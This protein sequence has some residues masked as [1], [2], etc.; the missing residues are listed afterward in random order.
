M[1]WLDRLAL[2]VL[3]ATAAA[4]VLGELGRYHWLLELLSHFAVQ[5]AVALAAAGVY[6]LLRRR[7][8]WVVVAV[9]AMLLPAWRL[10][11]YLPVGDAAI[12][13]A[14]TTNR[15]RVMT[16]NVHARNDRYAAVRAEIE[17]FD[18]DIVFLTETTERWAAALAPLR[19]RYPHVID[20]KSDSVFSLFVLSRLPLAEVAIVELPGPGG[21]PAVAAQVCGERQ[22]GA[23]VRLVGV[24]PPPPIRARWA[25]GRDAVLRA[26]PDVLAAE[27]GEPTILLG[28]FNCTPWSPRYRDLLAATGL[29]DSALGF[30]VGATWFSRWAPFGLKIDHILIGGGISATAH[31]I[32]Q[33]IGSDHYAVVADLRY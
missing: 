32:G 31:V 8:L 30:G 18:P 4:F 13:A 9:L 1:R 21:Y 33:D 11:P 24:H 2:A 16:V 3:I 26:I 27:A 15:L 23:C 7:P 28:D 5:Y 6:F 10:A 22:G 29:R 25:V 19:A 17:R 12:P 14:A 20:G